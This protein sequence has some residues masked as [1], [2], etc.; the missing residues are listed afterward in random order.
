MPLTDTAVKNAKAGEKI[1]RLPDGRGL[2]LEIAPA[3]GKR[4]R[5]RYFFGGKEN[6]LSLGTYP[7]VSL[8]KAREKRDAARA[9]LADGID[10]S[11]VKQAKK[12]VVADEAQTFERVATGWMHKYA[13]VWAKNHLETVESRLRINVL[14]YIGSMPIREVTAAHLLVV[15]Q[16]IE[17]RGALEVA[18]RVRGV[19]SMVFRYAVASGLADGDPAAALR[20]A[21]R[22]AP[23][24]HF[25]ALTEPKD[26]SGL[27]RAIA[28]YKGE[29]VV[30]AA[31]QF[32]AYTFVRPGELRYAQWEEIDFERAVWSIPAERTKLRRP[33]LVP[34]SKQALAVLDEIRPLTGDS[35]YVFHSLRSKDRALSENTIVAALRRMGIGN[36]EMCAHGFRSMASTSLNE[37]GWNRDFIETQLAHV[38]GDKVRGAYNRAQYW[39]ERRR[40]M[41]AWADYLDG[42][43]SGAKV[44]PLHS[45]AVNE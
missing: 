23:K 27:M 38:Q 40:M 18:K 12:A 3:G 32:L 31:M 28:D 30:R 19:L 9:L 21:L 24:R 11:A 22:P 10:P 37:Q 14:P 45:K 2:S 33:H 42:L 6:M 26:I 36:E 16:R 44:I 29:P 17:A 1:I 25:A 4:W 43:R 13:P 8:S 41:Q 5:L 7:E 20:G 35:S 39:P 15:L 34:L